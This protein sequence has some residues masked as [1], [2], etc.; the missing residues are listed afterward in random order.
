MAAPE[1]QIERE[2]D[3]WSEPSEQQ[4]EDDLSISHRLANWKTLVSFGLALL[5][6]AIAIVKGGIDPKALWHHIRTLNF[7]L[8]FGAFVVYYAT[9]PL[10]GFRWKALLQN[11][12]RDT[13]S[14]AVNSMS[15]RGL[16]EIL[17][18]SWFVNCVVPAKLG[19]LYRAYLAKL[20]ARISW[21]KTV[22]TIMA[23]RIIDILVLGLLLAATALIVFRSRLGHIGIVLI[24]GL[25]LAVVGI[26]ALI[27]MK[28]FSEHIRKRIPARFHERYVAFEEGTLGSFRRLPLILGV[29]TLIWL[30]EGARLQMV[31]SALGLHTHISNIPFVPMLFFALTM[32]V[33][34]TVPFT[35][36]GLGL[37]E[38]VLG[39]LMIYLGIS[40]QDAA[41]V[42]VVDRLL[43]YYSVA[44]FGFLVYLLS[45]RSHFRHPV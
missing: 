36:G 25:G 37:V 22:G 23:E 34:T 43:S 20:W 4:A 41:A 28:T 33:L 5:V 18:I 21:T 12:Y 11:A 30:M 27:A 14:D 44:F 8:F 10:R 1:E 9:F 13:H 17:Y 45:K 16:S 35:P 6:L 24:L 19:D 32:A 42:V 7:G 40:K 38:V 29:T 26:V 31:F 3:D 2:L 39:S 15:V